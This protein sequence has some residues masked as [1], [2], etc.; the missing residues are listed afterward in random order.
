MDDYEAAVTGMVAADAE[1]RRLVAAVMAWVNEPR[2]TDLR[3][4]LAREVAK[5]VGVPA[6]AGELMARLKDIAEGKA[7]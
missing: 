6:Y 5:G 3:V 4:D 7:A 2:R 1:R